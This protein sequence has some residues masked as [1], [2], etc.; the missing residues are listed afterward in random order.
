M[1]ELSRRLAQL[2]GADLCVDL[3]AIGSDRVLSAEICGIKE[4]YALSGEKLTEAYAGIVF[5][6]LFDPYLVDGVFDQDAV[7]IEKMTL[8][9]RLQEEYNDK[10][11]YCVRQAR[12][13]FY[14]DSPAGIE[15]GGYLRDLPHVTPATLKVEYD[16]IVSCASIEVMVQGA[17]AAYVKEKMQ[18]YLT[19]R[20]GLLSPFSKPI[21]MPRTDV[22]HYKESISNL[23]QAKLCMLFTIGEADPLPSIHCLRVAMGVFGSGPYSRLFRNVREKKSLCYYCGSTAQLTTGVMM[24]DS[25]VEPGGEARAEE[26]ILQELRDLQ[27]GSIPDQELDNARLALI[28]GMDA[29]QDS[30]GAQES[31]YYS[32]ILRGEEPITPSHAQALIAAVTQ[33]QVQELLRRYTCSVGYVVTAQADSEEGEKENG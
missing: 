20:Q 24:V 16:R 18:R 7:S 23:T 19:N 27:H 11:Q 21:A 8:E 30:L 14:A 5:G 26:A 33:R 13:R 4:Y 28:S 22:R 15:V 1:T 29:V 17:D 2:Y 12:R 32:Q 6:V 9:R 31:W 10:R 25:G 3:T